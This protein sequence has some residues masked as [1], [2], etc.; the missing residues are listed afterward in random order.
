MLLQAL[1]IIFEMKKK[2]SNEKINATRMPLEVL[3]IIFIL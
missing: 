1:K 2:K 3:Q